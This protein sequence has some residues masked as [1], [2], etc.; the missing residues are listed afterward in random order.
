MRCRPPCD[1][2]AAIGVP[3]AHAGSAVRLDEH[4]CFRLYGVGCLPRG[5]ASLQG[6]GIES[7]FLE[8]ARHTGASGFARSGTVGDDRPRPFNM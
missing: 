5:V 3:P 2:A 6:N 4:G 8:L 7:K 1:V